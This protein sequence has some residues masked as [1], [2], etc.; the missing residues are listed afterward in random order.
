MRQPGW[1]CKPLVYATALDKGYE[2]TCIVLVAPIEVDQGP[3]QEVWR[4]ENYNKSRSYG[5]ST[6]RQAECVQRS[7]EA[8]SMRTPIA[9]T[10]PGSA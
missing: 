4:P 3:G 2:P 9:I 10:G 5:P 1:S 6:L 7:I 8:A